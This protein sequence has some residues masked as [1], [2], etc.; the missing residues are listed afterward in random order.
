MSYIIDLLLIIYIFV[1]RE[2]LNH[3]DALFE[4]MFLLGISLQYGEKIPIF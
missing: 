4:E 3:I 1:A 2:F